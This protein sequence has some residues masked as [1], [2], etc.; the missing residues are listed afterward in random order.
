MYWDK[1]YKYTYESSYSESY[2][3]IPYCIFHSFEF[4]Y[5]ICLLIKKKTCMRILFK[6]IKRIFTQVSLDTKTI[7]DVIKMNIGRA[8]HPWYNRTSTAARTS[9]TLIG[10]L[11]YN[12]GL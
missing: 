2:S 5:M 9:S 8:L 4:K 3:M 1:F 12:K 10:L 6:K 11:E 7:S